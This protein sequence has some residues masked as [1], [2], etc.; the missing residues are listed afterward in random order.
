LSA[1]RPLVLCM[2]P[3]VGRTRRQEFLRRHG[4][5]VVTT[6]T[7]DE[8]LSALS[9]H[10]VD[11]IVLG[12]EAWGTGAVV[13]RMKEMKPHVPVL[14]I[15]PSSSST[16]GRLPAADAV[17]MKEEEAARLPGILEHLLNVRFPFFTRWFGNWKHRDCI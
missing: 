6:A 2:D 9:T 14:L 10:E 12:F 3:E 1:R 4:Y 8:G 17:V 15:Y 11:A 7:E 5:D 16:L 13:R